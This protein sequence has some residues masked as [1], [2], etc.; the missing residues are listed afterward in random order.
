M[1]KGAE[2]CED[3][4]PVVVGSVQSMCRD[5]RLA[6][7]APDAFSLVMVD[8]AHHSAS[9]S[10]RAVLEHFPNA[11]VLGVTATPDR[12]DRKGLAE[13]FDSIAYEYGMASAVRDGYLVP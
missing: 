3:P 10:Y 4:W 6:R 1:E 5:A 12:S 11:K 13:V 8:E 9:G 2:R 7:Y